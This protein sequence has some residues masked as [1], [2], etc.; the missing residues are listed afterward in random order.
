MCCCGCCAQR[1]SMFHQTRSIYRQPGSARAST[2]ARRAVVLAR[3]IINQYVAASTTSEESSVVGRWRLEAGDN[4]G[5][6]AG[7]RSHETSA[8]A[9]RRFIG[10][11]QRR[12]PSLLA[13]TPPWSGVIVAW[14]RRP[15]QSAACYEDSMIACGAAR[16]RHNNYHLPAVCTLQCM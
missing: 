3:Q 1:Q 14:R 5:G 15:E 7:K 12:G 10:H 16:V 13:A 4:C 6:A 11:R 2:T 9:R 8:N